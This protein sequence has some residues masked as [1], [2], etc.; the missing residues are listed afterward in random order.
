MISSEAAVEERVVD[1]L[2]IFEGNDSKNP[3][4]GFAWS[5]DLAPEPQAAIRLLLSRKR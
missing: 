1:G 5:R 4:E 2:A 3:S